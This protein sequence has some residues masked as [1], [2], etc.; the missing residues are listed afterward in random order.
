MKLT[1]N[2]AKRQAMATTMLIAT[3]C[4]G[5]DEAL[6]EDPELRDRVQPLVERGVA[7]DLVP[8]LQVAVV[9]RDGRYWTGSFGVAD[10][11]TGR[12]VTADTRFYIASTTKALTAL[13]AA[14]MAERGELDLDDTLARA[15][16]AGTR[17][18]ETY[19]PT[20]TTVRDLLTHTHGLQ[21]GPISYRVAF[22]GQ[23]TNELILELLPDHPALPDRD[24]QYSNF[25]YDLVGLLLAPDTD[26]GW[27][28]VVDREVLAPLGMTR[29]TAYRSRIADS[30]LAFPHDI[31][32]GG[33]ERIRLA[34]GD[35]NLGP[36]GG[37]FSTASDL[38]RL[39][40]AELNGGRIGE[41][42]VMPTAAI[43][44][45]QRP[46][47][48]QEREF[49]H[50]RRQAWGLGWDIGT[51]DGDTVVHR[52]GAFAG[53]YAN[54][55]FMPA[56]GFG[57]AVLSNGG[58]AGSRLA[59]IVAG[60]I[61][62]EL[63]GREDVVERMDQGLDGLAGMVQGRTRQLEQVATALELLDAPP[64][65][66]SAYTGTY[67][68]ELWGTVEISA[69]GGG[70]ELSSGMVA[71]PLWP[72]TADLDDADVFFA[73]LFDPNDQVSFAFGDAGRATSL[74]IR[75]NPASFERRD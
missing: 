40:L 28:D 22:T 24:F 35:A 39:L 66:L 7:R 18:H 55:A 36:A 30:L 70:L 69:A 29:T 57:I 50:Y 52:P 47:V 56:H 64:R 16:P 65:P 31:G 13:A 11:D 51:L 6:H 9:M 73:Q 2:A 46:Q 49:L 62:G 1:R 75:G 14:R 10:L 25:G 4:A 59:E 38:A 15:F 48:S 74:T 43:A 61:Y 54:A 67:V 41:R 3:A 45:T 63:L 23:Q 58:L 17:F 32:P 21:Q 33:M 27:K 26:R 37:H 53:Y 8:G 72:Q 34:K 60:A 12:P 20:A 44:E 5:A 68:D 71:G 19:D 42:Q